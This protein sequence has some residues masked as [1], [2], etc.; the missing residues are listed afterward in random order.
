[1][2]LSYRRR[3]QDRRASRTTVLSATHPSLRWPKGVDHTPLSNTVHL[4]SASTLLAC[5][6]GDVAETELAPV[7]KL[8]HVVVQR[9]DSS[10]R[11]LHPKQQI[12]PHSAVPTH[13]DGMVPISVMG[14][15]VVGDCG[16][17]SFRSVKWIIKGSVHPSSCS[18]PSPSLVEIGTSSGS[19]ERAAA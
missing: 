13:I 19:S 6:V 8:P 4:I 17:G 2:S 3:D 14:W 16:K 15:Q 11:S 12:L 7:A 18:S 9:R 10:Q 5:L 1:M